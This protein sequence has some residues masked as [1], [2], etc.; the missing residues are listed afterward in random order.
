MMELTIYVKCH[1]SLWSVSNI[2]TWYTLVL[3]IVLRPLY[4]VD[5]VLS[6]IA[7]FDESCVIQIE[8]VLRYLWLSCHDVT[9]ECY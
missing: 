2:I 7:V 4:I 5:S 3:A 8:P 1:S 6:V 9:L